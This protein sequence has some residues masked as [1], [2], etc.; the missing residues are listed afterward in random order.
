MPL[1]KASASSRD[2]PKPGANVHRADA[3][4]R[5]PLQRVFTDDKIARRKSHPTLTRSA[6]DSALPGIK[7]E[8]S[9]LALS[10][11]PTSRPSLQHSKRYTQREV[12]LTAVSQAT[13]DKLQ[14]KAAIEHELR[15]AIAAL[16]KP[17]P[18]LAVKELVESADRRVAG[19]SKPRSKGPLSAISKMYD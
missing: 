7:R 18:R 6:T 9:D 16:K 11:I 14:R 1:H 15:G 19:A 5:H 17:N 8:L 2:I 4:P 3:K 12:D 10:T 13:E